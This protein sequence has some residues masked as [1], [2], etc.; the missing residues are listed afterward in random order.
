MVLNIDEQYKARIESMRD[1]TY[2]W[3]A[4][5]FDD[6]SKPILKISKSSLGSFNWCPKKYEFSY[7]E[8][9]PQDQTEAMRKGTILHNYRED[10][11][12]E[13]DIKKA[14]SM[15]NSEIIEYATSLMPVD[16]YFDISLTV[17]AFEAQRFISAKSENK[18]H[19]YL[20]IVNEEMFD[21][22]ITIPK[23]VNKKFPLKQDYVVRLQGIIDR[24]FIEDG[25]LIPFEYKTGGWKDWKTTSMRQ[26][27][28]FYQ[29]MIENCAEE[30]L[31]K[32]GLNKDMEVSHWGWY[33]PAANHI[34]VEPVKKRSMTSVMNNIAKLI[35]A[36]EQKH[37]E[38][39]FYYKTC[40]HCSYFGIC[41]A[42]NT[43]TWL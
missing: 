36:Y 12:N 30:V 39:K 40:S 6:P 18:I 28:A 34:T 11:F 24:I 7:I 15:N 41:D 42:A 32:N 23:N 25:K 10:F 43:D 4:E 17:A 31:A 8:R 16:E 35:H 26:E 29:L 37:F 21:C 33:Y 3:D 19:E 22:E 27:M 2:K 1:F 20:P 38:T 13:F 14:E 9:L 5:A